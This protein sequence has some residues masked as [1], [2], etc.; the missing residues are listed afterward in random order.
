MMKNNELLMLGAGLLII[1]VVL[2]TYSVSTYI[3][4]QKLEQRI[5]FETVDKNNQLSSTEKYYKY[6]EYSDFLNMKLK[7]NRRIPLKRVSCIYLDYAQHNAIEMYY[8]TKNKM[9]ADETKKTFSTNNVKILYDIMSNY[10]S[11]KQSSGYKVILEQ[12]MEESQNS[13]KERLKADERMNEFLYGSSTTPPEITPEEE[14][15]ETLTQNNETTETTAPTNANQTPPN[16][17]DENGKAQT[18]TPEQIE[19]IN[20][21]QAKHQPNE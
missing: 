6:M 3:E 5:D 17:I 20:Q 21:Q 12:L 14:I 19:Y 1:G 13:E 7:E 9:S 16:Y 18:L 10:K 11:C 8:L 15:D 4:M 2:T